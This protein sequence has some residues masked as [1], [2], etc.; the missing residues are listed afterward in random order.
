[1]NGVQTRNVLGFPDQ[2]AS[3]A[4][5]VTKQY[6]L[7]VGKPSKASGLERIVEPQDITITGIHIIS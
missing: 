5:K 2:L 4:E 3:D 1:M 7:S 6:G